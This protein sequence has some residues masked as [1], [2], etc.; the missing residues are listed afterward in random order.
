MHAYVLKRL[1]DALL[2]TLKV[3]L[4]IALFCIAA[5]V[6]DNMNN[7]NACEKSLT[8]CMNAFVLL[9]V[10]LGFMAPCWKSIVLTFCSDS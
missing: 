2:V 6:Q 4:I 8:S 9:V 5:S 3:I 7:I 1:W 10:P